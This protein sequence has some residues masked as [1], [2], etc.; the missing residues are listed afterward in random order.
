MSRTCAAL[1]VS[2]LAATTLA[3]CTPAGCSNPY[4]L[5]WLDTADRGADLTYLGLVRDGVRS[6]PGATPDTRLCSVWQRVRN[7]NY[8]AAPGQQPPAGQTPVLLRPQHYL[9]TEMN[10]G[11]RVTPLSP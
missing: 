1:I 4:V 3:G 8:T 5:D 7:P 10:Q 6:A 2:A 11:W 9:V